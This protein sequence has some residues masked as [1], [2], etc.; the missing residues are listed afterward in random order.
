M[1][2]CML[3][4]DVLK[5]RNAILLKKNFTREEKKVAQHFEFVNIIQLDNFRNW[6]K[7]FTL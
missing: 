4:F 3:K 1:K 5:T 7:N 6:N 2:I